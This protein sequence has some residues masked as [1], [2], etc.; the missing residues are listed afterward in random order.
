[1]TG[2]SLTVSQTLFQIPEGDSGLTDVNM[3][4]TVSLNSNTLDRDITVLVNTVD[5]QA[6]ELVNKPH[7][8]IYILVL[9]SM[10][11]TQIVSTIA[12]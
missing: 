2:A 10:Y 8:C 3:G 9:I 7:T 11:E 12:I 4:L 1:M 6:S 5:A